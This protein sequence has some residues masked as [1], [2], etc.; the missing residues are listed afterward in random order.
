MN[1]TKIEYK[2]SSYWIVPFIPYLLE[3]EDYE[4]MLNDAKAEQSRLSEDLKDFDL[5]TNEGHES[6]SSAV[7]VSL[8]LR[9]YRHDLEC[10]IKFF[11]PPPEPNVN[12]TQVYT[13]TIA[14]S[15]TLSK[16]NYRGI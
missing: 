9:L 13:T 3:K 6:L 8:Q 16:R 1:Y 11:I 5:A 4:A 14:H 10:K 2:L 7:L 15:A 12:Q